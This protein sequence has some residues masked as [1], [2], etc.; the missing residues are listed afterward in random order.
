MST[1][2][3]ETLNPYDQLRERLREDSVLRRNLEAEPVKTLRAQGIDVEPEHEE[4]ARGVAS[5]LLS[6]GREIVET[7]GLLGADSD[8]SVEA[9][10]L[11]VY[12]YLSDKA[13]KD[14]LMGVNVTAGA[15]AAV[16]AVSSPIPGA[17][18]AI[19]IVSGILA[20]G[21]VIYSSVIGW[22][23]TGK[24]VTVLFTWAAPTMPIITGR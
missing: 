8:V 1:M 20:G 6:Q 10:W 18:T 11:G 3:L 2:T 15:A 5:I 14:V 4:D 9:G 19:A 23:N 13:A 7:G 24:G 21:L 22:F 16:A 17:G 12:V